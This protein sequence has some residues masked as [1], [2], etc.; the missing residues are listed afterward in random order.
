MTATPPMLPRRSMTMPSASLNP[1]TA[2]SKSGV[3]GIM[4]MLKAM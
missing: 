3:M 2:R 4:N 1:A